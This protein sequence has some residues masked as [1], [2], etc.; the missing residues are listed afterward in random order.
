MEQRTGILAT[1][2][3]SWLARD[4]VALANIASHH[5]VLE[6]S[7]G[8]GAIIEA[9]S[10]TA[11]WGIT[12]IEL[13][14]E[15]FI[16]LKKSFPYYDVVYLN[17]DFM[18]YD[19]EGASFDRIVM[20]PPHN[21]CLTHFVKAAELLSSGGRIVALFHKNYST[22]IQE[23]YADT[24]LDVRLYSCDS[25]TFVLPSGENIEASIIV[26]DKV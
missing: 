10:E 12:A 1:N 19:F 13:N 3:P 7:A 23:I 22:S 11:K 24:W 15:N 5:T 2:T 8:T 6:P 17:K 18:R 9:L 21:H 25:K 26:G 14:K 20:N 16:K 4:M